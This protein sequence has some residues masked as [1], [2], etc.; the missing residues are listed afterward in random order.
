[1]KRIGGALLGC[2][3]ALAV[4]AQH[5]GHGAA[6][7]G[8]SR[9][10]LGASAAF[11]SRGQL[12]AVYKEGGHVMLRRSPDQGRT[13]AP[14]RAVNAKPEPVAA[15]GDARPKLAVGPAG[16]IYVTWTQPLAR[17]YTGFIRFARSVDGGDTFAEPL[18]VHADRQEITH[19]FDAIAVTPDAKVFIAWIDKRDR[20]DEGF[21]GASLYYAVSDDRGASFRGDYRAAQHSCECCRIALVPQ[22]DGSVL[23]LWRHVFEPNVRDHAWARLGADGA[24]GEVR[25]ATFDDWRIDACP[26]HGP[27]LAIDAA[28]RRHAV[29]FSGAPGKEGVFYG[30]LGERGPEGKRRV[31]GDAAEHADIAV[32]GTRVAIA[33][34][35]FDGQRSTLRALRSDDAGGTWREVSLASSGGPTDQPKVLARGETFHVLWNARDEPLR[36]VALP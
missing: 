26:H 19:R 5:E 34:K 33:W 10:E 6:K 11:D 8:G 22:D 18:T 35:E 31:G 12:W 14:A 3:F 7:G 21:R 20:T 16:D 17:P 9:P 2:G 13:W 32:A 23:A 1:M 30:R 15:D 24:A 29:W 25:R 27:S 36:V 4:A 28:G